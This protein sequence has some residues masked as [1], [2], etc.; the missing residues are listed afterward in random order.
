[1]E[2]VRSE[3]DLQPPLVPAPTIQLQ[4]D[5]HGITGDIDLG[6]AP[7]T[8]THKTG[9]DLMKLAEQSIAEEKAG[10]LNQLGGK[11]QE[12]WTVY[13]ELLGSHTRIG[14]GGEDNDSV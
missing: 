11:I 9:P 13:Q 7:T 6:G 3:F 10:Q 4:V 1:M 2:M 5:D 14:Y 8:T 12:R